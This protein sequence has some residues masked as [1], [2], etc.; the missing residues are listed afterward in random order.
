M[1]TVILIS[2]ILLP[3]I[4]LAG[5]TGLQVLYD[6]RAQLPSEIQSVPTFVLTSSEVDNF[7]CAARYTYSNQFYVVLSEAFMLF[8]TRI[9]TSHFQYIN[10]KI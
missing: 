10:L 7:P 6:F 8:H 1:R 3:V 9:S 2:G 5:R 4:F